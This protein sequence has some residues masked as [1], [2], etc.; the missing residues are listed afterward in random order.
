RGE[1]TGML[2]KHV[3]ATMYNMTSLGKEVR[4][5]GY[6]V[7]QCR[8]RKKRRVHKDEIAEKVMKMM[9]KGGNMSKKGGAV[10]CGKC[11][12]NGHNRRGCTCLRKSQVSRKWNNEARKERVP[13][14]VATKMGGV[15]GWCWM[16]MG[17]SDLVPN[18]LANGGV[19]TKSDADGE[20]YEDDDDD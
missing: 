3:V 1:L 10:S 12:G 9:V 19:A 11:G 16:V 14:K 20:A 7:A 15:D 17:V 18:G 4:I 6:W 8:P 2:C 13:D 5:P